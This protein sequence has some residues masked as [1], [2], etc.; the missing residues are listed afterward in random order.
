[1][2]RSY[3]KL[4]RKSETTGTWCEFVVLIYPCT[5]KKTW[6]K[7]AHYLHGSYLPSQKVTIIAA[8]LGIKT[9]IISL[10][11]VCFHCKYHIL[12]TK[13]QAKTIFCSNQTWVSQIYRYLLFIIPM[14]Y[15]L[16]RSGLQVLRSANIL[17]FPKAGQTFPET[18][19]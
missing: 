9:S 1:M 6:I 17:Q 10:S 2:C 8:L 4:K 15:F 3:C 13:K 5:F 12:F 19:G 14:M 16:C 7:L 18:V 11:E